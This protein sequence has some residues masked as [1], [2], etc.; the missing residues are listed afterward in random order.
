MHD[1][2]KSLVNSLMLNEKNLR[3]IIQD[4]IN[5]INHRNAASTDDRG[6]NSKASG[7]H[8]AKNAGH[9]LVNSRGG[10]NAGSY[11]AKE[12]VVRSE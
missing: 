4:R 10:K 7:G 2:S 12:P 8:D 1:L 9:R 6:A 5:S 3:T 11:V